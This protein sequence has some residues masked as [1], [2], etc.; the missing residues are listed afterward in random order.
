MTTADSERAL[1]AMAENDPSYFVES[2]AIQSWAQVRSSPWTLDRPEAVADTERQLL[3][4]LTRDSFSEVI[5]NASLAGLAR[6]PGVGKG[7]R[8]KAL[9][10]LLE[11]ILPTQDDALRAGAVSSLCFVLETANPAI[12]ARILHALESLA[13]EPNFRLRM[14]MTSSLGA[15]GKTEALSILSKIAFLDMDGRVKRTAHVMMDH[16]RESGGVPSTVTQLKGEVD[17][18]TESQKKLESALEKLQGVSGSAGL[19]R[20]LGAGKS[21][22]AKKSTAKKP[23]AKSAKKARRR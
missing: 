8:P 11:K 15:T 22:A 17:R 18:L 1:K 13:M 4:W 2:R 23:S 14:R 21:S 16:L 5:R 10:A 6:L 9:D 19:T 7:E 12:S 3:Q 20:K